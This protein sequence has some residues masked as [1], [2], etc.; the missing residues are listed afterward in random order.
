[1]NSDI[2]KWAGLMVETSK[3]KINRDKYKRCS[4]WWWEARRRKWRETE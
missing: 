2:T 3:M 4:W 1:M